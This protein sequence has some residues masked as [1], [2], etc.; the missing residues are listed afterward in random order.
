M[1][2]TRIGRM[3][4]LVFAVVTIFAFSTTALAAY[5]WED[6]FH[7]NKVGSYSFH[8]TKVLQRV[9]YEQA[10]Y[11]P[12]LINNGGVDG[13]YG[14]ATKN[15]VMAFQSDR[16]FTGSN[17]DGKVGPMTWAVLQDDIRQTSTG[18]YRVKTTST[19]WFLYNAPYYP[20][21][22]WRYRTYVGS[23]YYSVF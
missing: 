9:L 2:K 20:L 19:D 8:E 14:N 17:V 23:A 15:A 11:T 1:K 4:I 22:D 3:I 21:D 13:S 6:D 7:L 10:A 18:Y 12:Y 16:G 5:N